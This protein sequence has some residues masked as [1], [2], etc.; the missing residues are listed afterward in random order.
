[1]KKNTLSIIIAK[2]GSGKSVFA[3]A[4]MLAQD[5]KPFFI[6]PIQNA[7][8]FLPYDTYGFNQLVASPL[9]S[10]FIVCN[11]DNL[12]ATLKRIQNL[13]RNYEN[14]AML[15][16]DEIDY[17]CN[18]RIHYDN[19]LHNLIN[20]GR[21][22]ELD[23]VFIARRFQDMPATILTNADIVYIGRNNNVKNDEKYYRNFFNS[24][25]IAKSAN[26]EV[27]Q[28]LEINSKDTKAK[29]KFINPTILKV[30]EGKNRIQE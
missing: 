24:E 13:A 25:L 6:T 20:Y 26:L 18:S 28:F 19:E 29:I 4:L 15:V 17:Y 2:K 27:G 23:I 9:Q 30:L 3:T 8:Y 21:H 16:I 5:K 7:F 10:S 1:M 11:R 12:Q 22:L 14:G